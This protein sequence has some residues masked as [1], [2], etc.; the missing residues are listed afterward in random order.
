MGFD[1]GEKDGREEARVAGMQRE[2][3]WR[4]PEHGECCVQG[5]GC[6]D[7]VL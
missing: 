2:P 4:D 5:K 3:A 1:S 7:G 6:E